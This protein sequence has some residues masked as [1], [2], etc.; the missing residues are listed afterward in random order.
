MFAG[1]GDTVA[2]IG[3]SLGL[4]YLVF[5]FVHNALTSPMR[6]LAGPRNPSFL[7]GNVFDEK[8]IVSELYSFTDDG[9]LIVFLLLSSP[10]TPLRHGLGPTDRHSKSMVYLA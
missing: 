4:T 9:Y 10:R 2:L 7:Y 6:Y 5:K 8:N 1:N 3:L